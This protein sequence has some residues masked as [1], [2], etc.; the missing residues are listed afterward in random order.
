VTRLKISA[1]P[2][3]DEGPAVPADDLSMVMPQSRELMDRIAA[4]VFRGVVVAIQGVLRGDA[5]SSSPTATPVAPESD[6]MNADEVAA[7][8]GVDRTTVYDFAGRGEI[9]HQR[10]GKRLLFR[11]GALVSWLDSSLCKATLTRKA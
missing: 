4:E 10:L 8:L 11:R 6:V 2:R 3:N 9:P 1:Q 5:P 7:F